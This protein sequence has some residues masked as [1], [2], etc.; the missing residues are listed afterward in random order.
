MMR[1]LAACKTATRRHMSAMPPRPAATT[2]PEELVAELAARPSTSLSLHDMASDRGDALSAAQYTHSELPVR[3]AKQA[4]EIRRA[5][6]SNEDDQA[7]GIAGYY[8]AT[9]V[10]LLTEPAP[11]DRASEQRFA[12]TITRL[13]NETRNH[14]PLALAQAVRAKRAAAFAAVVS[15]GGGGG[16]ATLDT[17]IN[18][19]ETKEPSYA[20]SKAET[21]ARLQLDRDLERFFT[22]RVGIRLLTEHYLAVRGDIAPLIDTSCEPGE[23][24]RKAA[25]DVKQ[26]AKRAYGTDFEFDVHG[27]K[28]VQITYVTKHMRYALGE[29]FKNAARAVAERKADPRIK[30]VIADG[31]ED[32][33]FKVCDEGGGFSRPMRHN[34]W[35]WFWSSGPPLGRSAGSGAGGG[36]GLPMTRC[37]AR[38]FGG[39]LSLRP[40]E[41]HGTD[42]YLHLAKL[43]VGA[44]EALPRIVRESP[45]GLVSSLYFDEERDV[46]HDRRIK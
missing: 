8:E 22:A 38:Y 16:V 9:L 25:D 10:E 42:A 44:C 5:L 6:G 19:V 40:L 34:A 27:D 36:L 30:V 39:E 33:A 23:V 4:F 17:K 11:T 46:A 20:P 7:S 2:T 32:L 43:G 14:I 15:R 3:L 1:A 37:L 18:G 24:V 13:L 26:L 12:A 29:L 21:A 35:S 45:G 28:D 31:S 41:G